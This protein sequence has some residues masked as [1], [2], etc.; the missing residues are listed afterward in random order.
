M[1]L[2]LRSLK[3]EKTHRPPVWLMRQAGRYLPSYQNL[4]ARYPLEEMFRSSSIAVEVTKM[5][6][7]L[8][9]VDAAILFSDILLI[10]EVF[11]R[12]VYFPE[13]GGPRIDPPLV[14]P[15]EVYLLRQEPLEQ[16]LGFT[17]EAVRSLTHELSVPLIGF[18]GGPFTIAS[19]M[20]SS[21]NIQDWVKKHPE[22][23][24]HLLSLLTQ[25]CLEHL[26]LQILA[27]AQVVQIFDSWANLL[28]PPCIQEFAFSYVAKIIQGLADTQVPVIVFCRDSSTYARELASLSPHAISFDEKGSLSELASQIPPHMGIQGNLS[29]EFLKNG[30]TEEI[31]LHTRKLVQSMAGR[32]GFI[33]NLGHGVLPA[34]PVDNVRAFVEAVKV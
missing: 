32:A 34:T 5:P 17:Y 9:G 25:A 31:Y 26:R 33:A 2:L 22:A 14:C 15:E 30:S 20:I 23:M 11:G 16:R 10:A 13:K 7:N 12:A 3:G 27:G 28:Q 4:R 18:C 1:S 8:L 29:P 21:G 24:H 19:Y 6:V